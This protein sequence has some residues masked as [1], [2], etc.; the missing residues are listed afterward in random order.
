M[1]A[2][3]ALPNVWCKI[4]GVATEADPAAWTEDE[5]APY[6]THA[7]EVFGYPRCMFGGDWPVAELAT[8]YARWVALVDRVAAGASDADRRRLWRETAI[9]V[10]RLDLGSGREQGGA[11][12]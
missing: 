10:Y 5:V 7:L 9:D 8:S 2:M 3:A 4:S 12:A 1:A 11:H 6:V